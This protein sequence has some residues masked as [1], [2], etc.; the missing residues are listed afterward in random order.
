MRRISIPVCLL[1][2]LGLPGLDGSLGADGPKAPV[3]DRK[4]ESRRLLDTMFEESRQAEKELF[5]KGRPTAHGPTILIQDRLEDLPEVPER[6]RL[7]RGWQRG[8]NC[9][10]AA[11]FFLLRLL[12]YDVSLEEVLASSPVEREGCSFS[13]LQDLAKRFGL[14]TTTV[15]K[16]AP[17]DLGSLPLPFIIHFDVQDRRR[18]TTGHFDVVTRVNPGKRID[19]IDTTNCVKKQVAYRAVASQYSGYVLVPTIRPGIV[20]YGFWLVFWLILAANVALAAAPVVR[21][22]WG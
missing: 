13:D 3:S 19:V 5:E 10:P 14:E 12:E 15:L 21:R 8:P 4:E 11:V 16:V 6:L 17:S 7:E 22:L 1:A 20:T 2:I 9:G 18:D